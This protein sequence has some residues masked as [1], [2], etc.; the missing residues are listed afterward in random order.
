MKKTLLTILALLLTSIT[1]M[2]KINPNSPDVWRQVRAQAEKEHYIPN[3]W[4]NFNSNE[5]LLYKK[6]DP[7]NEYTWSE[8]RS[9]ETDNC[10]VYW[11]NGYGSTA[12]DELSSSNEYY[13]DIDDLLE[14]AEE[15]YQLECNTLGFV[16][17]S[18]SNVSR[19]KIMILMNHTTGWVCY[20]GGYDFQ[21][22]ALWLS[23][24]TCHP[25]G[26]AVAHEVGHSFH[27]MCYSED[28]NYGANSN[29]QT[30]FHGAVGNGAAIWETTAN[31]Q[32]LQSYPNEV[33]TESGTVDIFQKSYNY[34]F[35]HEWHRY[36]AYMFLIYLVQKY[37]DVKTIAN[38]WNQRETTIKD[39]NQVLMDNKNL[40]VSDLYRLHFD[41]AMRA[42]TYDLDFCAPYRLDEYIGKFNYNRVKLDAA[43]YQ[44]AYSS[45]PQSTGF[46]VIP[47]NV[48]N[49]GVTVTTAFTALVPGC[50]LANGDPATY[51]NGESTYA[52]SG[53][54]AYNNAVS[55]SERGFRL[56][57]VV[58]K[59]DGTR[60]YY[61]DN[62]IHCTGTG[63][64]TENISYIVPE[65]TK[66][67]WLVVAPTPSTYIQHQWDE[68][69]ANDDQ[70]PYQVEFTN[71][72]IL[73]EG[74]IDGRAISDCTITYN[75]T[76]IPDDSG[77]SGTTISF[78]S[79]DLATMS[80]AFQLTGD[81]IFNKIVD[82]STDGPDNGEIMNYAA[83]ADGTLQAMGHSTNGDFGHW[84]QNSGTATTYGN[85][86]VVF[87]E[88][89]KDSKSVIIG[90]FPGL[91]S[92]GTTRTI[93][94]A[95]RYK[96]SS[97]NIATVY[98]VFNITFD[99][100]ASSNSAEITGIETDSQ[101]PSETTY[102]VA[103]T[104][105]TTSQGAGFTVVNGS[106]A[107]KLS[108]SSFSVMASLT[109][110]NVTN[111]ITPLAV[112]GYTTQVTVSGTT[113]TIAYSSSISTKSL[114]AYKVT[115][116]ETLNISL[117][118]G[119]NM[120]ADVSNSS[121][122][123]GNLA[124]NTIDATTFQSGFAGYSTSLSSGNYYY[125]ALDGVPTTSAY[126]YFMTA[127]VT[128][129][130]DFNGYYTHYYSSSGTI[131]SSSE[132]DNAALK[133][134][135]DPSSL[136]FYVK[137]S[138]SCPEGIYTLY[139]GILGQGSKN[140][141]GTYF[142]I[143]VTVTKA[144]QTNVGNPVA[145]IPEGSYIQS[146]STLD[147]TFNEASSD[148]ESVIFEMLTNPLT[149]SLMKDGTSVGTA[150]CTLSDN[151]LTATFGNVTLDTNSTYTVTL[152]AGVVGYAGHATNA[153]TTL[154]WHTPVVWDDTYYLY[155]TYTNNYLS[156]GGVWATSAIL[157]DWGLAIIL[158]TNSN[159]ITT[160]RYFDNQLYL[161]N[162]GFCYADGDPGL[163]LTMQQVTGGYKF[164]NNSNDRYLAV[165][166]GRAV[167]DAAEGDNL[168]GT[169]NIWTLETTADHVANYQRN[170]DKQAAAA[171]SSVT[172]LNGITTKAELETELTNNYAAVT[173]EEVQKRE[174]K[175]QVYAAWTEEL[176]E[177]EYVKETIE[178]VKPGLYRLTLDAFQRAA[179]FD[180]VYDNDGARGCMYAYV[181]GAKT[182]LMSVTEYSSETA[183]TQDWSR[184]GQT[185]YI[186]GIPEGFD[187]L[188]EGHYR[189]IVY[190]YVPA[191]D[192]S[193][194]GTIVYGI[195]NPNRL[196]NNVAA[197]TWCCYNTFKLE[198][199]IPKVTLDETAGT[200]P[201]AVEDAYV[202]F[203]RTI[204][205][206]T[207]AQSGN[208]W[209][210][211]CFPFSM[212]ESL[213]R[214]TFGENTVVKE[215]SGVNID[216][217][218]N[219]VFSFTSVD[220]IDANKPYILQ[221]DQSGTEYTFTGIDV[222]PGENTTS[223]VGGIDFVGVYTYP[224]V[225][226][227]TGGT[228]YYILNDVFKSS[229]GRTRIKGYR[230]YFHIPSSS[231]IKSLSLDVDG[232]ATSIT[233]LGL[234][235]VLAPSDIYSVGGQLIRKDATSL[236]G[237]PSGIYI[238]NGKKVVLR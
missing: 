123:Y 52:S 153:E 161:Y 3:E 232:S 236:D 127:S 57:Y 200:V 50:A 103:Y 142:T 69:Y 172:A 74:V 95:L 114:T 230:A 36:Q 217:Y 237:L 59:N 92:N 163:Q 125:Y 205:A 169:S 168:D 32:A 206:N 148:D 191:D 170:A 88:F 201:V 140:N 99:S 58:L 238:V 51:L 20:G 177:A 54:T 100:S 25:V 218:G 79:S 24:S 80:T 233:D 63:E 28:S 231:S 133:V 45:C 126:K 132:A 38:V 209:N 84:F 137:A 151:T 158:N 119:E 9:R 211:I 46:N 6:S 188:D 234:E 120:S 93:R 178:N 152:P 183:F 179:W 192:G 37:G 53:R 72:N 85:N 102:D 116:V 56:G 224:T 222:T 189:N 21:I 110:S 167:G 26:S 61:D 1:A 216:A 227:N 86:S 131:L 66:K 221:T 160:L 187:V 47:L 48:P 112:T 129:D 29:I 115:G 146:L 220:A 144:V 117:M 94:E 229:T 213:I 174:E 212:D 235:S 34:A 155:N 208:A 203:L 96:D 2:A 71:T 136:K 18:T 121:T 194:T 67:M 33:F 214:S 65:N 41:F 159:G 204:V 135:F 104:G 145:S 185:H 4:K 197:G 143:N 16:D 171:A 156:R 118:Q 14:K 82:Y 162:D 68:N 182:Q 15:F 5:T 105:L 219:A 98:L 81:E 64:V 39:F 181:N 7:N 76:L 87:A 35:T 91:N 193:E 31:W 196:G 60:V 19:Y 97:G 139:L 122:L 198:R 55:A 199:L 147:F 113:V 154:T 173:V 11:D 90:Q 215:L 49:A 128:N 150:T 13:V 184:D 89:Y 17:P 228:D 210:T 157:D 134:A 27:Y 165:W 149:L 207:N 109:S 175:Y 78:N 124:R 8:S 30:G 223:T 75:V 195:N 111:Y 23:P 130:S 166:G 10:I 73:G 44:V 225:M 42:V 70:W 108:D 107:T 22:S 164:L 180:W 190:V 83:N 101:E 12:P 226:S 62:A 40:S 176:G 138:S 43:K 186:N 141:Y 106:G 77:Y 202:T